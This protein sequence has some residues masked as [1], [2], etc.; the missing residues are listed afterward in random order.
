MQKAIKTDIVKVKELPLSTLVT[1]TY[2][3]GKFSSSPGVAQHRCVLIT[4]IKDDSVYGIDFTRQGEFRQFK[5]SKML[6]VIIFG[7][8]MPVTIIS[9]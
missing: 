1:F 7:A 2:T 4:E 8:L 3:G 5:R 9:Q 6:N